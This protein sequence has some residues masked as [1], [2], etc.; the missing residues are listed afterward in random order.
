[1]VKKVAFL[2]NKTF[3]KLRQISPSHPDFTNNDEQQIRDSLH[4]PWLIGQH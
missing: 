1:V 2:S 4:H 3:L